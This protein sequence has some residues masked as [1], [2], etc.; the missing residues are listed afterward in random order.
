MAEEEEPIA[1]LT[2]DGGVERL[3]EASGALRHG[4][5][6][7]LD[8]GGRA[9]DDAEDLAR[10]RLL[11]EGFGHLLVRRRERLVPFPE[12]R[13]QTHVLERD[14]GLVRKRLEQRDLPVAEALSL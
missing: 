6:H 11:F 5:E 2:V 9:R 13:E 1:V 8:V 3:A 4:V 7:R 14:H 12:L 10:R